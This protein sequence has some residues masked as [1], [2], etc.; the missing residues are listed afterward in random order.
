[1]SFDGGYEMLNLAYFVDSV[2]DSGRVSPPKCQ[3]NFPILLVID[4]VGYLLE[5]G[6]FEA[7]RSETLPLVEDGSIWEKSLIYD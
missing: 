7:P 4:E 3:G 1:M 5:I 6:G 2:N